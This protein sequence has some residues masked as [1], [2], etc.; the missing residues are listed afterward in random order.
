MRLNIYL[1]FLLLCST[2]GLAWSQEKFPRKELY[3]VWM[4]AEEKLDAGQFKEAAALYKSYPKDSSFMLRT[5]QLNVI[6]EIVKEAE[7]LYKKEQYAEALDKYKEYRKLRDIGTLRYFEDKIEDCLNQINKGNLNELTAQQRVITGFEFAHRGRE[8]LSKLDTTGAKSD[9]NNAKELGGNR[10]SILREQYLEGLRVADEL[11]KWGNKNWGSAIKN[12]PPNEELKALETYRSIR[13][14]DIPE[15]ETRIRELQSS[16]DGKATISDIAKL[17]DIDLL[18]RH[19]ETNKSSIKTSDFLLGRLK[20]FKS[21][22]QKI[23]ILKKNKTNTETVRSAYSS[24]IAWTDDLPNDIRASMKGCIQNE[25]AGYVANLPTPAPVQSGSPN[26]EGLESFTKGITLVRRELANCDIVRSKQLWKETVSFLKGCSNA[27]AMLRAHASLS[28]S[29]RTFA[30]SDSLLII[31]RGEI[32]EFAKTDECAKILDTYQDMKSLKTCNPEAL[33]AEINGGLEQTRKC[34]KESWFRPQIVGSIAG[35]MPNYMIGETK[36]EMAT[37]WMASGGI[38][39]SYI[40]HKNIAEFL[41]GVEYFKTN[42]YSTAPSSESVQEDFKITGLNAFLGIKLHLPNTNPS[43][44]RPYLRFGPELQIPLSYQYE[45]YETFAESG[46]LDQLQKSV[47]LLSGGLGIE[48]QK[49]RF[50]AFLEAFGASGL[51]N[52]YN[53][54]VSHLT[55][56]KEKVEGGLNK[57]GIKIGFRFW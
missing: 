55:T 7:R 35:V 56:T 51:G 36:K 11:G 22:R 19:V 10:N 33:E 24:L 40:D 28:D 38:A 3:S 4:I 17:C 45:N 34:Q 9:F 20:E 13:N 41:A 6:G 54:K 14:I 8:K 5:R 46:D 2:V 47:L 12:L 43:K 57:F 49:E 48:I 32:E 29:I 23:D 39:L 30:K 53:S 18:I 25:Y 15:V 52:I 42:Y 16:V 1:T 21:T 37:G 50:G 27:S 26:C 31:Y 44:L